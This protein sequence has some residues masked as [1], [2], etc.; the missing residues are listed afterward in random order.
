MRGVDRDTSLVFFL[1]SHRVNQ[2]QNMLREINLDTYAQ[3]TASVNRHKNMIIGIIIIVGI[4]VTL[5]LSARPFI[6]CNRV[7]EPARVPP[8]SVYL[9]AGILIIVLV[10]TL[11]MMTTNAGYQKDT[12]IGISINLLLLILIL[13][14]TW[15]RVSTSADAEAPDGNR[16]SFI[17]ICLF[18]GL[19]ALS[20]GL[21]SW[22]VVD[23]RF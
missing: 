20:L 8:R 12:G 13:N 22:K 21:V 17:Q 18:T 4:I 3:K 9:S 11:V 15:S 19:L 16:D 2:S 14:A 5:V 1:P 7:A 6:Q 10:L 23:F